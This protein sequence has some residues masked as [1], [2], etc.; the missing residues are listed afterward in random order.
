MHDSV[1][2]CINKDTKA[3]ISDL[4]GP[5]VSPHVINISKQKGGADCGLS[6]IAI[7]TTLAIGLDPPEI[8][9]QQSNLL[10]IWLVALMK[11]NSLCFP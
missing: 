7:A 5:T 1:Y 6:A 9:F 11:G 10:N 4:Y 8:T 3:V 2:T